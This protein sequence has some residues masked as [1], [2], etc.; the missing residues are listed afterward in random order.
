M[1]KLMEFDDFSDSGDILGLN[2]MEREQIKTWI[3]KYEKYFNFHDSGNFMDSIDQITK[4]ALE[5][6]DIDKSKY[7]E[8]QDYIQSLYD[9]S[10]GISV[11]MA[12]NKELNLNDIDQVQRF[13]Y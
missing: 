5:Q 1:K 11:I 12:P 9:L 13:Q 3:Q 4:D 6:L 7:D 10:D 8:V 2:D